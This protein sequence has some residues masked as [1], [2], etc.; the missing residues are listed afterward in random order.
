MD[1][2]EIFQAINQLFKKIPND[3]D[4]GKAVRHIMDLNSDNK[5]TSEKLQD[6]LKKHI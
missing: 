2:I 6:I 1:K 4:F 3:M 5:L